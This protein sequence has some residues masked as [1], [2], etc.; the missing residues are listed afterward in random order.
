MNRQ[1]TRLL[2]YRFTANDAHMR[3]AVG[4]RK[5]DTIHIAEPDVGIAV[6][7][8]YIPLPSGSY[9]ATLQFCRD[10]PCHGSAVMDV[11]AENGNRILARKTICGDQI[12]DD[13]MAGRIDFSCTDPLMDLEVRLRSEGG[14]VADIEG[15]ELVGELSDAFPRVELSDLP[16]VPIENTLSRGRSLYQG[17]ERGVG[18]QFSDLPQ[19]ILRD[20]DFK[21]A[22]ELAGSR[23]ILGGLNLCNLF[24]ILKFYLPRLSGGGHIVEFGSYKGGGAIFM[25]ALARK[26]LPGRRVL[27]FD[28]F[29]GMPLTDRHVDHHQAGAFAGVDIAEL[30][31]YIDEIGVGNLELVQ[32]DFADSATPMLERI[33]SVAFAHLDCD[34]R[35]AIQCAYDATKPHMVSGGYWILDDPMVS[36]CLGAAE[37]MEDLL[38]R[39]DG[40]NSE[41]VFPHYVFRQP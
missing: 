32:G 25:A 1:A 27:A 7:G 35:S 36:D 11:C 19:K 33:G 28:T 9:K 40:L 13:G 4:T 39:R 14:F 37:A 22:R 15:L 2:C 20:P 34:I 17:Y 29:T 10:I 18:L 41:Q 23:T 26:F 16:T 31:H 12:A 3:T 5:G 38:I 6:Y 24:L 21:E 8:P 30:R